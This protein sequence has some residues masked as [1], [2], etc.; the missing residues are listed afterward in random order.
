MS[1]C[2]E[3]RFA[4]DLNALGYSTINDVLIEIRYNW[5]HRAY[6][7]NQKQKYCRNAGDRKISMRRP[8]KFAR[9]YTSYRASK[10]GGTYRKLE[11]L[12]EGLILF[13]LEKYSDYDYF[14]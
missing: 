11:G 3:S 9:R 2:V 5:H 7:Q 13:M 10:A 4:K 8:T 12:L 6:P 1:Q 14:F